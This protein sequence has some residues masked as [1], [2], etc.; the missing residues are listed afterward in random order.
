[1]KSKHTLPTV[2]TNQWSQDPA[3]HDA[4]TR[5]ATGNL[6]SWAVNAEFWDQVV[7]EGNDMYQ[8]LVL[9]V[10]EELASVKQGN[11]IL[12]LGTGNGI[13]ARRLQKSLAAAGGGGKVVASDGCEE[14]L[15]KAKK[16]ERQ[17]IQHEGQEIGKVEDGMDYVQLDLM[18]EDQ[19]MEYANKNAG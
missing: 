18:D 17:R 12:D 16:R 6:D 8:E 10:I 13:G 5:R 9:P 2:V 1:M 11:Q 15:Q 19:L 4:S 14:L 7:G 3:A